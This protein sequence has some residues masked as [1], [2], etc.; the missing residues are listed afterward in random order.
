MMEVRK[1]ITATCDKGAKNE[2][3]SFF[4]PSEFCKEKNVK[5]QVPFLMILTGTMFVSSRL[6][7]ILGRKKIWKISEGGNIFLKKPKSKIENSET[8]NL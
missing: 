8:A 2:G 5:V 4:F 6:V 3:Q 1:T 7:R